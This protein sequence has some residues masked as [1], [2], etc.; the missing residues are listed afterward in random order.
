MWGDNVRLNQKYMKLLA[1][2]FGQKEFTTKQAEWM[3]R[4]YCWTG[5]KHL[6]TGLNK[7]V[8]E[9]LSHEMQ[10]WLV[11]SSF[12]W[13]NVSARQ[14]LSIATQRGILIRVRRGV[15]KFNH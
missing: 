8:A 3:Y 11:K 6:I 2:E 12:Y 13:P 4:Q 1:I 15:Y 9:G 5:A 10:L 7:M 14:Y